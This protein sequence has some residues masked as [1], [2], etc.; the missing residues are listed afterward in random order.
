MTVTEAVY[1]FWDDQKEPCH[2]SGWELFDIMLARTGVHS[3]PD[4]LLRYTRNY[5]DLTGATFVC[6][7]KT[8]ST[9]SFTPGRQYFGGVS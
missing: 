1:H 2:I 3:Y 5:C 6:V 4:T 8:W 9:Y 7:N